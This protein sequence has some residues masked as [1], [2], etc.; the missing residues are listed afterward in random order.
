L[1]SLL[2]V[3]PFLHLPRRELIGIRGEVQQWNA[4]LEASGEVSHSAAHAGLHPYVRLY[5]LG[6][7]DVSLGDTVGALRAADGLQRAADSASALKADALHTFA[8]SIRARVAA[9][10]GRP[11]AALQ[12]LE[13]AEW[14]LVESIFEAEALDRYQRAEL[15]YTL[16]RH[17]EALGWYR[18]IAERAT[19]EL[20]YV[21]PARWREAEMYQRAGDHARTAEAYRIVA[22]L[23]A[24]ADPPLR[25]TAVEARRRLRSLGVA[26]SGSPDAGRGTHAGH[27]SGGH[28]WREW[29]PDRKIWLGELAAR[30]SVAVREDSSQ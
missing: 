17:Q 27:P 24:N 23:W 2:A 22:R 11:A 1:R 3:L 14:E 28:G 29:V 5:R 15:L 21:A 7:L 13:Q 18:T 9:A 30:G 20:V 6:L 25:A 4:R 16:G 8:L 10:A 12:H 19:Y 26:G